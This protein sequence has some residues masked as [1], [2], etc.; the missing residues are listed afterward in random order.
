MDDKKEHSL[1]RNQI[2][3]FC[4]E[5]KKQTGILID[6]GITEYPTGMARYSKSE[7]DEKKIICCHCGVEL[8]IHFSLWV[9]SYKKD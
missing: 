2:W 5:C 3:P 4:P 8:N 7:K 9:F 6:S 1:P